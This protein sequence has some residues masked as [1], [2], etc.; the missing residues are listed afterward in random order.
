M[1]LAVFVVGCS[2]DGGGVDPAGFVAVGQSDAPESCQPD[3]VGRLVVGFFEAFNAG[4]IRTRVDGFVAPANRLGWFS[5]Q[6]SGEHLS[7]DASNRDSLGD[8][9]R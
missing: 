8:Y 4:T 5:V 3:D 2:G 9:L 7:N 1:V 6:G